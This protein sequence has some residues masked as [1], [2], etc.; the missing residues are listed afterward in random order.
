MRWRPVAKLLKFVQNHQIEVPEL[1][2]GG[3]HRA[4]QRL[5]GWLGRLGRLGLR[6]RKGL[7]QIGRVGEERCDGGD[8]EADALLRLDALAPFLR[9]RE[10]QRSS[11][12]QGVG[13]MAA[14]DQLFHPL[15]QHHTAAGRRDDQHKLGSQAFGDRPRDAG[16]AAARATEADDD[17]LRRWGVGHCAGAGK[18][19]VDGID[20][21]DLVLA[22]LF[23]HLGQARETWGGARR[24]RGCLP[25][26]DR[27]GQAGRATVDLA[28]ASGR[29]GS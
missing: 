14:V 11:V 29:T 18:V 22:E 1:G 7:D 19:T 24:G 13:T 9:R 21:G 27:G 16:F 3:A 6:V 15:R 10:A 2:G 20:G 17:S 5:F 28:D 4:A 8:Q 25:W 26:Y 12:K 23:D